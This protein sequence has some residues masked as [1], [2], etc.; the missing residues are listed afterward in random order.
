L[1]FLKS[2][3]V[4]LLALLSFLA[5][6]RAESV[7]PT[8]IKVEQGIGGTLAPLH[9]DYYGPYHPYAISVRMDTVSPAGLKLT[10]TINKDGQTIWAGALG[11]GESSPTFT[12]DGHPTEVYVTN[13][14][15]VTVTY[16]G[17]ITLWYM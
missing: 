1:K 9:G 11:A 15:S 2:V 3:P 4:I 14:N 17:T 16:T 6:A 13:F 12:V 7:K 8:L 5:V 10:V